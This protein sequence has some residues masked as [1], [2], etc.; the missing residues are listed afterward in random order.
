MWEEQGTIYYE[1][2][3][4]EERALANMDAL[5]DDVC[6]V[7]GNRRAAHGIKNEAPGVLDKQLTVTK[8]AI[9]LLIS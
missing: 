7:Q 8:K 3:G 9:I 5:F 2:C 4:N 1:F 6:D